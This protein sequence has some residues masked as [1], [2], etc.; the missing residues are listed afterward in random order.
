MSVEKYVITGHI[1][2]VYQ[3]E[4]YVCGRGGKKKDDNKKED[5]ENL[6]DEIKEII[7]KNYTNH[8]VVRSNMIRRLACANFSSK[9]SFITLTFDDKKVSHDIH[10]VKECNYEFKN[11]IKRLK[12]YL[13]TNDFYK[14]N[15]NIEEL[16]Y[17]A[18]IEFQDKNDRRAVHYHVLFNFP[19][20]AKDDLENI[21]KMGFVYI[22]SIRHVDNVGAYIIKYMTKDNEDERLM[23]LPAYLRSKNLIE[24]EE[25]ISLDKEL[26][27]T[28]EYITL[29]SIVSTS[30]PVYEAEYETEHLG[31][32]VYKQ[33][34]LLRE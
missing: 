22:T 3:Y 8:N 6:S 21:W 23:G 15:L 1:L 32:C 29:D 28:K 33:Y 25:V 18:V 9:S 10:N 7:L 5:L 31:K 12:Y 2:E 20:I 14:N 17:L 27:D 13:M 11:F 26:K 19:F 4:K 16:K 30:Y 34:N 24:P